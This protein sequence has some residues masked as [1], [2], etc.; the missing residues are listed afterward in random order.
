MN[1]TMI[2]PPLL[3]LCCLANAAIS[4]TI[5][6][7]IDCGDV[8]PRTGGVVCALK[9]R[10]ISVTR[11]TFHSSQSAAR[12][13]VNGAPDCRVF[14]TIITAVLSLVFTQTCMLHIS[15]V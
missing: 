15:P 14:V 10:S 13:T 12:C 9:T 7:A 8:V 1:R 3:L 5:R 4:C 6:E 2:Q 11:D